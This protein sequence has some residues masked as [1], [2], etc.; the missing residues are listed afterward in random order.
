MNLHAVLPDG[1]IEYLFYRNPGADTRLRPEEL[2]LAAIRKA[3]VLHYDSMNLTGGPTLEATRKAVQVAR[4][5]GVLVS[6]D[7]NYRTPVWTSKEDAIRS[8][9]EAIRTADIVKL[10]EGEIELLFAG[11]TVAEALK[12]LRELGPRLCVATLGAQGCYY[13][14]AVAEGQIPGLRVETVDSI[15][16]GDAFAGAMLQGL[17]ESGKKLDDV[18]AQEFRKIME[19]ATAASAL[20]ATR[21]G[22]LPALPLRR[23][24]DELLK[25]RNAG[26]GSK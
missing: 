5:S 11:R 13:C 22:A 26:R 8:I 25:E 6:F 2:D 21:H 4:E 16:C 17:L 7:V 19:F 10:N 23:E 3:K 20:T 14:H 18:S 24:V 15:G 9:R 12:S 1:S